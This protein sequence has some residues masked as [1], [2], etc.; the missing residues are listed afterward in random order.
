MLSEELLEDLA[1]KEQYTSLEKAMKIT[2]VDLWNHSMDQLS[3]TTR[4]NPYS[5]TLKVEG[6]P[7]KK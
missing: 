1:P 5:K 4:P 3:K 7:S 6:F 2:S